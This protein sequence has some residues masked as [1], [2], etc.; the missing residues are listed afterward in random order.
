[1]PNPKLENLL[2]AIIACLGPQTA[3]PLIEWNEEKAAFSIRVS[4]RDQG[5]F[6][7]KNGVAIWAIKAIFWYAGM[8]QIKRTVDLILLEPE[9]GDRRTAP[10]RSNPNWDDE[11]IK[12]M[13][14]AILDNCF[15]EASHSWILEPLPPST[16]SKVKIFLDKYLQKPCANPDFSEAIKTIILAAGMADGA[17]IQTEIK[18]E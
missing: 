14:D 4:A 13:I 2:L 12:K 17:S 5:R 15:N 6:I 18:W 9:E 8:A 10:F 3:S 7:G 11:K 1:M 16:E